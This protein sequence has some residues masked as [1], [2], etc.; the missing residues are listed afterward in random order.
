MLEDFT[1]G[2]LQPIYPGYIR[3][4]G[5]DGTGGGFGVLGR[6]WRAARVINRVAVA[7]RYN[8][9]FVMSL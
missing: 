5:G 8:S 4:A 2:F 7:L 1:G 3:Q 6:T 9:L